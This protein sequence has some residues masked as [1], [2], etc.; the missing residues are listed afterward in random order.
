MGSILFGGFVSPLVGGGLTI[1]LQWLALAGSPLRLRSF[2]LVKKRRGSVGWF[3]GEKDQLVP[4]KGRERGKQRMF[5][6]SSLEGKAISQAQASGI[7]DLTQ[8]PPCKKLSEDPGASEPLLI[9]HR[10]E[11]SCSHWVGCQGLWG[12]S[13]TLK[14]SSFGADVQARGITR[15][16]GLPSDQ[17][18]W[19]WGVCLSRF[20]ASIMVSSPI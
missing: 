18:C 8:P 16:A 11:H 6:S 15:S 12:Y 20:G 4:R 5:V 2:P 1:V 10:P 13:A 9:L 17:C 3:V 19:S 14:V 7:G